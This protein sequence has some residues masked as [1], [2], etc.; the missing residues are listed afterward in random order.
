MSQTLENW[1]QSFSSLIEDTPLMDSNTPKTLITG[2]SAQEHPLP[3]SL[4][5]AEKADKLD[6]KK[7]NNSNILALVTKKMTPDLE[8]ANY[9]VII[10]PSPKLL[11]AK[12]LD[13]YLKP[14][15][16]EESF[17][18][19]ENNIHPTAFVDST[20]KIHPSVKI[21]PF[22]S[23]GAQVEIQQGCLIGSHT[24]IGFQSTIGA[25]SVLISHVQIGSKSQLGKH[26]LIQSFANIGSEGFGYVQTQEG[27]HEPVRHQGGV[28]LE[29]HVHIGGGTQIDRGTFGNTII[30][31][32]TK[33]D[34]LCHIAHNCKIGRGCLLTAGFMI[35]GSSTVGQY[36][37]CGGKTSISGHVTVADFVTVGSHGS[38]TGHVKKSGTYFGTPFM[39]Y[40]EGLK[41]YTLTRNLVKMNE[42]IRNLQ[43]ELKSLKQ[44][45]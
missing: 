24:N 28:I 8:T 9:K 4:V 21:G 10:S 33:I 20:A 2:V 43:N 45:K 12:T 34:N 16:Y 30:G 36:F 29:D 23:I 11:M 1:L 13:G 32:H 27:T 22:C 25:H 19:Q 26:N 17:F 6:F 37:V 40:R 41:N 42:K 5:F 3:Q 15:R 38:I 39:P 14:T 7:L 18:N 31:E 35:A 44:P